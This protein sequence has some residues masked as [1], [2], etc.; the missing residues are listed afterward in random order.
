MTTLLPILIPNTNNVLL[1]RDNVGVPKPST[2]TL[3]NSDF[4]YGKSL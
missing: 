1:T 3:P 2:Y 4:I